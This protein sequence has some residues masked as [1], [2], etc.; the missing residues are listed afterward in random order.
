MSAWIRSKQEEEEGID[1]GKG[2]LFCMARGQ[3]KQ[4]NVFINIASNDI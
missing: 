2:N 4:S 3:T 1:V